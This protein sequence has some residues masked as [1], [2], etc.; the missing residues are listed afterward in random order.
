MK[1]VRAHLSAQ[2]ADTL[3]ELLMQHAMRDEGL[4]QRLLLE[5]AKATRT[6]VNVDTYRRA[7]DNA[8]DVGDYVPYQEASG[9]FANIDDVLT[10]IAELADTH[11]AAVIELSEY[12]L[13][14]M[15]HAIE[16]VDD[17]DGGTSEILQRMHAL[18]LA[19][20][21]RARPDP[22]ALARMLF[23][24]EME[25]EWE[26]FSGAVLRYATLLGTKGLA[27]YRALAESAWKRVPVLR[28]GEQ[29][30]RNEGGRLRIMHIMDALA[31]LAGDVE[32]RVAVRQRDLSYAYHYLE[33]AEL[34]ETSGKR[35][36]ALHWA[37]QGVVA[38]PERTDSRLRDFLVAQYVR[39]GRLDEA[40]LLLWQNFDDRPS[41][42]HYI[43]LHAC[44]K[45]AGNWPVWRDKA[46]SAIRA[47]MSS[48]A[49]TRNVWH[50]GDGSLLVQIFMWEKDREVA[51]R[52][53]QA[54]G[55]SDS[56]WMELAKQREQTHPADAIGVYQ[57]AVERTLAQ[58]NNRAYQDAVDLLRTVAR[59]MKSANDTGAM[60]AYVT[61]VRTRHKAKRNFMQLLDAMKL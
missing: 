20:C 34:Y 21:T 19:A 33:I 58:K 5:T 15:E 40:M 42:E 60:T 14:Q 59:V 8:I 3:V 51:W 18:H 10:S 7:L 1:D 31:T 37:E 48:G 27:T 53:A 22:E 38:F 9:Y 47:S 44:A 2:R 4:R 61:A 26:V 11:P 12:A 45:R 6:G 28:A 54:S 30:R 56:L 32:A 50:A 55:C 36:S 25:S 57:R 23:A 46:L 17:S 13:T 52:E 49:S 39:R 29:M 41:L 35:D 16:S 24:R 43:A